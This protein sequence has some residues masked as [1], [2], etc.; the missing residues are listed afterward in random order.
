MSDTYK[1]ERTQ[2]LEAI[3]ELGLETY[4]AD[5]DV[6]GFTVIPPEIAA[7]NG[8]ADRLLEAVLEVAEARRGVRPDGST[9][10]ATG[11]VAPVT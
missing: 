8:L 5:L 2:K 10:F 4:V 1:Q 9:M 11:D 6:N 3:R 7:P